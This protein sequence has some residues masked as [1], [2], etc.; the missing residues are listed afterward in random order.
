M[1]DFAGFVAYG[2]LI[3]ND[4]EGPHI[5]G[6]T[7][8]YTICHLW[9]LVVNSTNAPLHV[10]LLSV[11][12][13]KVAEAEIADFCD[14]IVLTVLLLDEDVVDLDVCMDH[15]SLMYIVDAI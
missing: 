2:H 12:V 15:T 3:H 4:T 10:A 7:N 5:Y 1:C 13:N 11:R 9:G 6:R 8:P 14:W